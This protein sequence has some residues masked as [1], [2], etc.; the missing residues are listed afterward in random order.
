MMNLMIGVACEAASVPRNSA[1]IRLFL[2]R[3][4]VRLPIIRRTVP[5]NTQ[6]DDLFYTN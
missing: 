3:R 2:Q 1:F 5:G 4:W 6:A